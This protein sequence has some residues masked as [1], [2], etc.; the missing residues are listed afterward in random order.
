[1]GLAIAGA[2][3]LAV[4]RAAEPVRDPQPVRGARPD[5]R[6][7]RAGRHAPSSAR[8]TPTAGSTTSARSPGASAGCRCSPPSPARVARA[9]ARLAQRRCCWSR[10]RSASTS[11][12]ARRGASSAAGCCRSTRRCACSPATA[13]SPPRSALRR[14]PGR[15]V[16]AGLTALL[17]VQGAAGERPRRPR[18][19]AAR[20]RAQQALRWIDANVPAGAPGSWSSRSSRR[21]GATRSTAP[22]IPVERPFQAYEKRLRV[23][24]IERYRER[25]YCWVVV[26]SHAEG[27]RPEGR[28]AQL[29]QLLPRARRGER[30]RRSRSRPTRD[31]RRAGAR[32]PT[33]LVQLPAAG[34]RAARARGRD[35][36]PAR[37]HAGVG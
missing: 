34:V 27:A 6:P 1:M 33:T 29:A 35:P 9:A 7:V 21:P 25:G 16:L 28:A 11:T 8:T 20:T 17:C 19:R 32:S 26:G 2:A 18:A 23:R 30:A 10:S 22:S 14:A 15:R 36:P 13:S 24:H 4:L 37:L 5:Q 3:C 12:W 31:G